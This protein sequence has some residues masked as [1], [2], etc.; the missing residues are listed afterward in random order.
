M[1]LPRRCFLSILLSLLLLVL[2][3]CDCSACFSCVLLVRLHSLTTTHICTSLCLRRCTYIS[4]CVCTCSFWDTSIPVCLTRVCVRRV[5][6]PLRAFPWCVSVARVLF[7]LSVS[8][9]RLICLC[10]PMHVYALARASMPA[11]ACVCFCTVVYA[12]HKYFHV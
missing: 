8:C 4:V 7:L 3:F 5:R 2:R 1:E 9:V 6:V 12:S 10:A 11:R